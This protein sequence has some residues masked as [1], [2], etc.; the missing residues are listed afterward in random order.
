MSLSVFSPSLSHNYSFDKY[1]LS[2]YYVPGI[3]PSAGDDKMSKTKALYGL[4]VL[5][6]YFKI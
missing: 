3:I 5:M 1:L 2:T 6:D 4:Y